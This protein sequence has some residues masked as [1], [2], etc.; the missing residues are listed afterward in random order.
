[1]FRFYPI[2]GKNTQRIGDD[3]ISHWSCVN[4]VSGVT[5]VLKLYFPSRWSVGRFHPPPQRVLEISA[6]SEYQSTVVILCVHIDGL[7]KG[8]PSDFH[9]GAPPGSSKRRRLLRNDK[10]SG[11]ILETI[12]SK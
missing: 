1:M 2:F 7:S 5:T 4:K 6:C 12:L 9:H 10:V 8:L 3:I 11:V